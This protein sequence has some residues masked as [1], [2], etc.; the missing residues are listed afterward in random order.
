MPRRPSLP[1]SCAL[2]LAAPLVA[3]CASPRLAL[4]D[5]P[6][7]PPAPAPSS[8]SEP[9]RAAG[10]VA[11]E[12]LLLRT[13]AAPP[14]PPRGADPPARV[15]RGE[16]ADVTGEARVRMVGMRNFELDTLGTTSGRQGWAE[17]RVVLGGHLQAARWVDLVFEIDA[18][19]GQLAGDF[20]N[21]GRARGDDTFQVARHTFFGGG[22]ALPRKLYASFDT[23]IGRILVGQQAFDWGTGIL[24]NDG[25]GDADFGDLYQGSLVERVAFATR[26]WSRSAESPEALKNLTFFA[27]ADLAF[28]DENASLLLGDVAVS[29]V[30][31]ARTQS[32]RFDLGVLGVIRRQEDR[33]DPANGRRAVTNAYVVDG[34]ARVSLIDPGSPQSLDL[35]GEVALIT[36]DTR[37]PYLDETFENGASVLSLGAVAR[38]RFDDHRSRLTA[39]LE[40]G[41]A[42]GDND[43]HDATVRQFTFHSDHNVGLVLFDHVM[44]MLSARAVDRVSDGTLTGAQPAST[45]FLVNQGA[46]SNAMY[47][48]PTFRARPVPDLDLRFGYVLATADADVIDPYQSAKIGGFNASYGGDS[49]GSRFLGQEFDLSARYAFHLGSGVTARVGTELG[50]FLPG[51]AFRGV[52]ESGVWIARGLADLSF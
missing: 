45:R 18:L 23:C 12:P 9:E 11:T 24:A 13:P 28:R 48:H 2:A 52:I 7:P 19:N 4:A 17:T 22:V 33:A 41:Y 32:K 27:A 39:K 43:P 42:S 5:E 38:L 37:R 21:V 36:G 50:A 47:L 14:E 30:L 44:P 35:E 29:G 15:P 25:V 51:D 40:A 6:A 31:G 26:P 20:T 34:H 1:A 16:V 10:K 49:P 3:L 46:V 8:P